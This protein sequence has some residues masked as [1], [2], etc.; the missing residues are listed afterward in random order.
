MAG[1]QAFRL[2]VQSGDQ[3]GNFT[4]IAAGVQAA[5]PRSLVR[6]ACVLRN[7]VSPGARGSTIS[8]LLDR[9]PRTL[10]CVAAARGGRGSQ[11]DDTRGDG[12]ENYYQLDCSA[13]AT[14]VDTHP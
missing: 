13:D 6:H 7:L 8:L 3:E 9:M 12:W 5:L 4:C 2:V 11:G 1:S 10:S 14:A